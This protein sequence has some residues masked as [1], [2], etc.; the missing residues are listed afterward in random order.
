MSSRWPPGLDAIPRHCVRA[1]GAPRLIR[2]A[3]HVSAHILRSAAGPDR[4]QG[5]GDVGAVPER[6]AGSGAPV[7]A[8]R[9]LGAGVCGQGVTLGLA[10]GEKR[11]PCA[12]EIAW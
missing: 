12:A 9:N 11:S 1:P 10:T 3:P 5:A 6:L 8:I 4:T 2:P 7:A